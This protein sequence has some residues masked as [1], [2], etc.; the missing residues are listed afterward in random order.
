MSGW[1]RRGGEGNRGR[2][3][4][5]LSAY[6]DEALSPVE[7]KWIEQELTQDAALRA[8]LGELRRAVELVRSLPTL[9]VPRS[10]T[11]DPAIYSRTKPRR[12]HIYPVLRVATALTMVVFIVLV[13][14]G[15]VLGGAMAPA[16]DVAMIATE[17]TRV[18]EKE[19]VVSE[20]DEVV[21]QQYSD[22]AA[23]SVEG[24]VATEAPVLAAPA[25][26]VAEMEVP[27]EEYAAPE[28]EAVEGTQREVPAAAMAVENGS[29]PAPT[30]APES[31]VGAEVP[32]APVA[33]SQT[34]EPTRVPTGT[35]AAR[36]A[37]ELSEEPLLE[38]YKA[39]AES[40]EPAAVDEVTEESW[41]VPQRED[42]AWFR[43]LDGWHVLRWGA[44]LLAVGLLVLTLLARRFGW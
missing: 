41:E 39:V 9:P 17:V 42:K 22:V 10:F 15:F 43:Q 18:V 1:F 23:E 6:I 3:Q 44:G 2:R 36:A 32:P 28:A 24:E 5:A 31:G 40:P 35:P 7:R 4:E 21:P 27:V 29:S 13:T 14:G 34:A 25:E 16:S 26:E 8:E 20:A 30:S 11:L 12:V 38:T 19:V 37:D 33:A